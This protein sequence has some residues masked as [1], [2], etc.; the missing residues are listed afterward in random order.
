[1]VGSAPRASASPAGSRASSCSRRP[2]E[3]ELPLQ[4]LEDQLGEPL[5]RGRVRG[6][7]AEVGAHGRPSFASP[8][9]TCSET[10]A[11]ADSSFAAARQR[12]T[13]RRFRSPVKHAP[14][15][16]PSAA[17]SSASASDCELL[18][19]GSSHQPRDRSRRPAVDRGTHR[20]HRLGFPHDGA[21]RS[22]LGGSHPLERRQRVDAHDAVRLLADV[23]L[24]L[25]HGSVGAR[26]EQAVLAAGVEPQGVQLPLERADVVAA[27][28][29]GAEVER[30][31]AER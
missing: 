18:F 25:A 20:T 15:S 27:V 24:E 17:S 14:A 21:A 7:A 28:N 10:H 2:G 5:P 31:V 8:D 29:G 22:R 3:S 4:L 13:S 23:A 26:A 30:A 19:R 9:A 6:R 11:D 16:A 12:R 1:M